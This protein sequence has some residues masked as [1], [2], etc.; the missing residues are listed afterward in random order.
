MRSFR[1][2]RRGCERG[3]RGQRWIDGLKMEPGAPRPMEEGSNSARS[4]E[5]LSLRSV[6][7]LRC[8]RERERVEVWPNYTTTDDCSFGAPTHSL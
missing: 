7:L 8:S 2:R 1:P 5:N 4:R 3:G 6:P